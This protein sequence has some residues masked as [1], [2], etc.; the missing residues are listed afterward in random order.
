GAVTLQAALTDAASLRAGLAAE[1]E[2][3]AHREQLL[4]GNGNLAALVTPLR[5][6]LGRV[7]EQLD[8]VQRGRAGSDTALREQV[9]AMSATSEQLRTETAQLVTA[10]RAPQVRG[11][12]GEMQLERVVEAAGL[13]EHVD[14]TT[15][16]S[17]TDGD[18][19]T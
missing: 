12:W 8:E 5:D 14:F 4:M 15:Q 2:A 6:S 16:L 11:R 10:L 18:G 1:R 7:Q 9:R 3:T 17:S 13:T 19:R